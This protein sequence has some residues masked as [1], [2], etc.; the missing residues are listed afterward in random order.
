MAKVRLCKNCEF[1]SVSGYES[2]EETCRVFG[3]EPP[4]EYDY[5]N[6]DGDCGCTCTK[7][8]LLEFIEEENDAWLEDVTNMM[9]FFKQ[10]GL[11]HEE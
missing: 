3:Y 5:C 8:Q 4:E 9:E 1:L 2:Y 11:Y 6:K 10:E 7:K